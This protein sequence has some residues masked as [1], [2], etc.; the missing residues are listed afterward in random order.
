MS[1]M[2]EIAHDIDAVRRLVEE[3]VDE[4]SGEVKPL[5]DEDK[6]VL[7]E[8]LDESKTAFDQKFDNICRFSRNLKHDAEIAEAERAA[9][10]AEMQRL[11]RRA[12]VAENR[13]YYLK[14]LIRFTF[15]KLGF[16][17][18][19]TALFS[20]GVQKTQYAVQQTAMFNVSLIP[21]KFLKKELSASAVKEAVKEGTLYLKDDNPLYRGTL[22]YKE[23]G[24]EKQLEGVFY[25]QGET[26]VIR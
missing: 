8:W 7:S 23:G 26:L 16:T 17:K 13:A 19:K 14:N 3:A 9:M 5:S 22:F 10:K 2:Y 21:D 20:A 12:E 6:A 15:D 24:A 11:S 25:S 4:E 1:T 18:Y